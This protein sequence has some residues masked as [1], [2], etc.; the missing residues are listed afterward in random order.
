MKKIYMLCIA[1]ISLQYSYA[2]LVILDEAPDGVSGIFN[3]LVV[4]DN[5]II[6]NKSID[7]TTYSPRVFNNLG[8]PNTS[9]DINPG[10]N[11]ALRLKQLVTDF[12]LQQNYNGG[13]YDTGNKIF[14]QGML[15]KP[16]D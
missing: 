1:I 6:Y 5:D 9:I 7:G 8:A 2:Q 16:T 4:Y 12:H 15:R 10:K 14:G 13:Y 11:Q 3:D